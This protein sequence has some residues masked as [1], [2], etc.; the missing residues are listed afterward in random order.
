M[1]PEEPLVIAD[2]TALDD[3]GVRLRLLRLAD[4]TW[5]ASAVPAGETCC[6]DPRPGPLSAD[7]AR[8]MIALW[9]ELRGE[10][11]GLALAEQDEDRLVGLLVLQQAA[12]GDVEVA[13]WIAA[14]ERGRSYATRAVSLVSRWLAESP[15]VRRIWL[16]T[17]P[18]NRASQRVAEK[19]GFV[20]ER[21]A[22]DHC[23][24]GGVPQ[25]CV[26]YAL[27]PSG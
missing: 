11:R 22:R 26:I 27:P 15:G 25:D 10:G 6:L 17:D 16:E 23:V 13:Y 4:A 21:L 20:R 24:R 5:I 1:P 3:D 2:L 18:G 19:A 14:A 7:D 9:D 12:P 8:A